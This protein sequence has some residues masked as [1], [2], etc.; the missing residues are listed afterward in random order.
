MSKEKLT[1]QS[2]ALIEMLE[3][4]EK[5]ALIQKKL[6]ETDS[7]KN[8]LSITMNIPGPIK[9]NERIE[10][11]F[12]DVVES[13]EQLFLEHEQ[14]NKVCNVL[15]TGPECYLVV[16]KPVIELKKKMIQFEEVHPYGRLMDLDVLYV[17]DKKLCSISRTELGYEARRC[18]ICREDAKICGRTA[19]H[20]SDELNRVLYQMMEKGKI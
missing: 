20:T 8:L 11:I 5:R 18:F 2:V 17:A 10:T 14:I 16:S 6:L 4:R 19:K 12:L 1:G 15:K 3:A 9:T 13:I 7:T